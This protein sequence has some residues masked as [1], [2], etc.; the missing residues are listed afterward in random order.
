MSSPEYQQQWREANRE[1]TRA[2]R[3]AYRAKNRAELYEKQ[4]AWK[5]ANPERIKELKAR[6]YV[7]NREKSRASSKR[8][9]FM[10]NYGITPEQAEQM[11]EAQDFVCAICTSD[12]PGQKGWHVD[13]CHSS[14]KVR[15]IL[16]GFCNLMLGY[17]R[18][19]KSTLTKAVEYLGR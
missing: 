6:W 1:K 19:N 14:G 7:E 11:L 13:H 4:T 2:Y 10:R 12:A 9:A 5:E 16:C 3:A 18:D 17:A 15:G 8:S